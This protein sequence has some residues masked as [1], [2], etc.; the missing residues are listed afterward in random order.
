MKISSPLI[1]L[2]MASFSACDPEPMDPETNC[3]L[4]SEYPI[5]YKFLEAAKVFDVRTNPPTEIRNGTLEFDLSYQWFFIGTK[6][7]PPFPYNEYF[8]DMIHFE[9]ETLALVNFSRDTIRQYDVS[10]NDC[11]I[12]L[13]SPQGDLHFELISSGQEIFGKRCAIFQH[14]LIG[15]TYDTFIF[16]EFRDAAFRSYEDI[17]REFAMDNPGEF[18]TIAIE[19]VHNATKE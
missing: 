1:F 5:G 19:F 2:A 10:R 17:I 14:R 8:I 9:D 7:S 12:D 18:D 4:L 16:I 3:D 13:V 11:R 15:T 6:P